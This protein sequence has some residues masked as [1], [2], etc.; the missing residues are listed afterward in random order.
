MNFEQYMQ[1]QHKGK[2]NAVK[3]RE[4]EAAFLCKGAEVRRMVNDL[5]CKGI[6]ICSCNEG[7]Y[8][9]DSDQDIC[10]TIA[11]LNGRIKKMQAAKQG[12]HDILNKYKEG[13]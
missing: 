7:Y 4:I 2:A 1:T 9:A 11:H 10:F 5:R 3:S 12:M 6:P 13:N 8:Y